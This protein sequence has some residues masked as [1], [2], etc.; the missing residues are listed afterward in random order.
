MSWWKKVVEFFTGPAP[1]APEL[2][3]GTPLEVAVWRAMREHVDAGT[4][5]T[6]FAVASAATRGTTLPTVD[7]IKAVNEL[8]H[9]GLLGPHGYVRTMAPTDDGQAWVYHHERRPPQ[10]GV[11]TTTTGAK[12]LGPRLVGA[13][14]AA[15]PS[16][17][18]VGPRLTGSP[19][20][21]Q[22]AATR[23]PTAKD[24]YDVGALLTLTKD[25]LRAR[26]L[27]IIPW[28]T[29]WIG[30]VDVI[31][32]D[33]DERTALID[34]GLELRGLL[35]RA[36]ITEIHRIGDLWLEHK[37]SARLADTLARKNVEE[38]LAQQRIAK[39]LEKEKKKEEARK[40][41]TER[42][43]AVAKRRAEDV[44]HLGRGVSF[45][46]A[47]RRSH[48]E[49]LKEHGLPMLA[50]PADVA[51]ALGV[52]IPQLRFLCFHADAARRSHYVHFEVP[53]RSGGM[54][55]LSAP[56]P[57]LAKAQAWVLENVLDKLPV[58]PPAHG[59]V[60]G[61]STVTNARPHAGRAVVVN[62][63]LVDF[64]PTI[65]FGR[66]RGVFV[67]AGYSP[68]V[69]T[70][71]ALLTTESPRQEV[72]YAGTKYFVALGP[73]ALPQGACTSPALSNQIARKLDRRLNGLANKHGWRYT[74]YA[75]DLSFSGGDTQKEDVPRLLARLR[76][77]VDEEG[78]TLHIAK[79][80]VQR[81]ARQQT[82][83][84]IVVNEPH[85]LGVPREEVR[86]LR[87]ILHNAKKTGLAA[88]NRE[89]RPNFEAWLR[90][91]IAYVT[92]VDRARGEQ[93]LRAF[94]A[95]PR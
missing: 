21:A 5:F 22:P 33:S 49:R 71:F 73:R 38:A 57:H 25:E 59:F 94:E 79:G 12:P 10:G 53:K 81:A 56:M 36:Q 82:V 40:R 91:K 37:D 35:T 48:V 62:Q 65:T 72:T 27:K 76:H 39:Q 1:E 7:A 64:F 23:A 92:M 9:R 54:R 28:K 47:D 34:R 77:V 60:K 95:L 88:Q 74:R 55:R 67:R 6:A 84:G 16:P 89:N 3:G 75:D 30:R 17:A 19:G 42:A 93:L 32:P 13:S 50:T 86:R 26:A 15:T 58:E 78:F 4:S 45:G 46:L 68:A 70:I 66:V 44:I 14:P 11:P 41:A 43:A 24:P 18:S 63:D 20:S 61:R 52:T 2:P 8:F 31:P 69:A 80:R 87:A 51:R 29:A 90:G 85:K 83:T